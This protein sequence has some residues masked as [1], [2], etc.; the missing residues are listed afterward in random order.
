MPGKSKMEPLFCIRWLAQKFREKKK[1]LGMVLIDL[2]KAYDRVSREVLKWALMRKD[3]NEGVGV[4]QGST[5]IPYL[6]FVD[7]VTKDIQCEVPWCMMFADYLVL[8]V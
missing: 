7:E 3:L 6:F 5:L 1:K 8:V 2:E 4:H